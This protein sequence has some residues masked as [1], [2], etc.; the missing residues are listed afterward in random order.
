MPSRA[1]Q[2]RHT[3]DQNATTWRRVFFNRST[4]DI[5]FVDTQTELL[6]KNPGALGV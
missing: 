2:C 5:I 4:E 6:V 1:S 3:I